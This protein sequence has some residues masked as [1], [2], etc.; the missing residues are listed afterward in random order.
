LLYL[1]F[2]TFRHAFL[3]LATVPF[4]LIDGG[5]SLVLT[6]TPFSIS[7]AVGFISTLRIAILGGVLIVVQY[8]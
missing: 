6:Q 2:G 5:L 7:A 4:A 1:T 3:V 8:P